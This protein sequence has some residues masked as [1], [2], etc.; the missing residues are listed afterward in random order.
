MPGFETQILAFVCFGGQHLSK[1]DVIER[2]CVQRALEHSG[3]RIALTV[4]VALQGSRAFGV[5]TANNA[6]TCTS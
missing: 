1:S 4:P 3:G 5:T 2:L 6:N